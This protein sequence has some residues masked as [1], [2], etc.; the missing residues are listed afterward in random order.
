MVDAQLDSFQV[1]TLDIHF[2]PL[3][4]PSDQ[5]ISGGRAWQICRS[6]NANPDQFG[7]FDM[8]GWW[9]IWGNVIRDF[10]SRN[11]IEILDWD[12]GWGF[13]LMI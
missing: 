10:L 4:M 1:K 3:N 2:D 6:G 11:K 13:L 7:I 12:G 8:H 5:F 9:F